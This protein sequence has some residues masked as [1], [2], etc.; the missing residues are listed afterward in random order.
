MRKPF[1]LRVQNDDPALARSLA[2]ALVEPLA[3]RG[4]RVKVDGTLQGTGPEGVAH[5]LTGARGLPG[6]S[7]AIGVFDEENGAR[8]VTPLA[9]PDAAD[10][11]LPRIVAFLEEWGFIGAAKPR[12][13]A[14]RPEYAS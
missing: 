8:W 12:A 1:V 6:T 7:V 10:A 9:V 4:L 2:R 14:L 11:A 13:A 3:E 5:V